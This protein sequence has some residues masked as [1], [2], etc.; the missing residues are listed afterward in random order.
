MSNSVLKKQITDLKTEISRLKDKDST[1]RE[2]MLGLVSELEHM[3]SNPDDSAQKSVLIENLKN[4]I[5]DFEIK[6][7]DL[8]GVLNRIMVML[9]NMGI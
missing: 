1:T 3:I 2:K 6:H 9:S 5:E 8:T 4:H 7:P